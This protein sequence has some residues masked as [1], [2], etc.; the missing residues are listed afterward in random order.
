MSDRLHWEKLHDGW[1]SDFKF[2]L[3]QKKFF[4]AM[5]RKHPGEKRWHDVIR[6]LEKLIA[7]EQKKYKDIYGTRFNMK[8]IV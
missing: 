5:A 8:G 2:W 3:E 4:V 7:R 1:V 6:N